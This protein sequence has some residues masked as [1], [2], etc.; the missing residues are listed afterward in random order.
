MGC[1]AAGGRGWGTNLLEAV[2]R[3]EQAGRELMVGTQMRTTTERRGHFVVL[4]PGGT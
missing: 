3:L 2:S 1:T 4:I